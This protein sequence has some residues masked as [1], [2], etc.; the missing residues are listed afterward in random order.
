M[1][2]LVHAA[3]LRIAV[4]IPASAT[5]YE[6]KAKVGYTIPSVLSH[7]TTRLTSADGVAV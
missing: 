6:L 5:V 4:V 1:H 3:N 7:G 2:I